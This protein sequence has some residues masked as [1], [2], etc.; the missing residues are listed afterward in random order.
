V[1]ATHPQNQRPCSP[2]TCWSLREA[3][4][5][6]DLDHIRHDVIVSEG[7]PI[8]DFPFPMRSWEVCSNPSPLLIANDGGKYLDVVEP[9]VD[10][11][12]PDNPLVGRQSLT[13]KELFRHL[14]DPTMHARYLSKVGQ[15]WLALN[16]ADSTWAPIAGNTPSPQF[17]PF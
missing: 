5:P 11:W 4:W 17:E 16:K 2:A 7:P 10:P 6:H 14:D 9:F 15:G 1:T 12:I 3:V 13:F 8:L